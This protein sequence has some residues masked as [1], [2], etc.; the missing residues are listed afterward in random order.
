MQASE[1]LERAERRRSRKIEA[2]KK[3]A[4]VS[5]TETEAQE[6]DKLLFIGGFAFL[7]MVLSA[8]YTIISNTSDF[9]GE[10]SIWRQVGYLVALILS[11]VAAVRHGGGAKALAMPWPMLLA[12]GWCW[13]SLAWALNDGVA[14]RRVVLTTVV[15]WNMFIL[16][17]AAGYERSL[18]MLRVAFV[19]QLVLCYAAVFIDPATGIH[20]L[21]ETGEGSKILG[22]W[23]GIMGHKNVAGAACAI[24]AM[25]FLFDAKKIK[26]VIRIAVIAAALYFLWR[27]QSKTSGGM[28]AIA[29]LCGWIF[30]KYDQRI[31]TFAIPIIM[32]LTA[33]AWF[34]GST[35]K[36]VVMDSLF[37]PKFFTGRGQIWLGLLNY[38]ADHPILGT[39]FGSFWNIGTGS[40]IY[41]YGQAWVRGIAQGHN[42]YLDLLVTIGI[43]GVLLVVFATIVWPIWRLLVSRIQPSRGAVAVALLVFGMGHNITESSLFE[44]DTLI[45]IVMMVGVAI[46][47]NW[48]QM[49]TK[50]RRGTMDIF[51]A[52]AERR[53]EAREDRARA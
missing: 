2:A 9:S 4:A 40:P 16:I 17:Q 35:Y 18:F 5:R 47:Q 44:R 19:A 51:A 8:P 25:L 37:D 10:G 41:E 21:I 15:I 3:Q 48:E 23:R 36:T 45:G 6:Q 20:T 24:T 46:A 29:T 31:R 12:L 53:R 42:G 39:G 32:I 34:L 11:I 26:P 52:L 33:L 28:I 7:A 38:S 27:S 13:L 50:A 30:Q 1:M 22:N 43:P 49:G 14:I